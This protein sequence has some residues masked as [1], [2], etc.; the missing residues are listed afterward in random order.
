MGYLV[1]RLLFLC[2]QDIT[3]LI[4]W[5]RFCRCIGSA[6]AVVM[7]RWRY[8]HYP[9]D[10]AHVGA[11]MATVLFIVVEIADMTY[12]FVYAALKKQEK[13]KTK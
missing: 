1:R 12:P 10:Y 11:P 4:I 7:F 5:L 13:M 9:A 2:L 3:E 6:A 8:A